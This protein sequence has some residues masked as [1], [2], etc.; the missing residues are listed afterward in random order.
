MTAQLSEP[1]NTHRFWYGVSVFQITLL[2]HV[3]LYILTPDVG[4]STQFQLLA[5]GL[6]TQAFLVFGVTTGLSTILSKQWLSRIG[7][8][9]GVYLFGAIGILFVFGVLMRHEWVYDHAG[10]VLSATF[11][12]GYITFFA[13]QS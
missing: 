2:I 13:D 5:V 10:L 9:Q 7:R 4:E 11:G 6:F 8:L 3:V 12:L 1:S